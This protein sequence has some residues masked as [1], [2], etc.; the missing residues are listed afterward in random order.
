MERINFLFLCIYSAD[1]KRRA[2]IRS[3]AVYFIAIAIPKMNASKIIY[4]ICQSDLEYRIVR[5]KK[6]NV[7]KNAMDTSTIAKLACVYSVVLNTVKTLPR[8]PKK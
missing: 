2:G 3:A 4:L 5:I 1:T 8:I 7:T 6:N